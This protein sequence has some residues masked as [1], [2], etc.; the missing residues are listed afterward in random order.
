MSSRKMRISFVVVLA[1]V[2]A[3]TLVFWY[4]RTM[5]LSFDCG[6]ETLQEVTLPEGKYIATLFERNCGATTPYYRIVI[7]RPAATKL[8]AEKNEDWVFSVKDRPNIQLRWETAHRLAILSDQ[9]DES[10]TPVKLWKDV[11]VVQKPPP[12]H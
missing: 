6:V 7:L 8:D 10:A 11:E 4:L 1:V 9:S 2:I 12:A 5:T 3:A